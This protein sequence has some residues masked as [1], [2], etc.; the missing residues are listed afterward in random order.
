MR[1]GSFA[2]ASDTEAWV[3]PCV[4]VPEPPFVA[5]PSSPS[6]LVMV[7][8]GPPAPVGP[9][10]VPGPPGPGPPGPGP[11]AAPLGPDPPPGPDGRVGPVAAP[12][13]L[14]SVGP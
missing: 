6:P 5:P 3:R 14:S 1:D 4:L 13:A 12:P 9:P 2:A 8:F 10:R 7:R 11:G